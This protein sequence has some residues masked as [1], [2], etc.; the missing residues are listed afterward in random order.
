MSTAVEPRH[1]EHDL[2]GAGPPVVLIHS[3]VADARLW[4]AQVEALAPTHR[5]VTYDRP[6]FGRSPL[7]PGPFSQVADL[8]GLL[9]G[10]GLERVSLVGCSGGG[11]VALDFVLT[12]PERVDRLVLVAPGLAGWDWSAEMEAAD[13]EETR[14]FEAGDDAGAAEAQVRT[15]ADGQR[16][17]E[18]VDPALREYT[19][20]AV[21]RSYAHYRA[22]LESG[23]PGPA[24]RPDPPASERLGDVRAPTLV[25]IGE[26]D[27][28]DL[29]G[30]ADRLVAGIP[31][32]RKEVVADAAH[33]LPM[34][35]P[36]ELNRRLLEFL[37]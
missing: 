15:W 5:V 28:E 12:H 27:V 11:N 30:V 21:L 10:L 8:R 6:G 37:A 14:L 33:M 24:E 23:E 32:A 3:D 7:P 1:V 13:E 18:E 26:A 19:R 35:R 9:D 29:H 36:D 22:A 34:E 31:D 2:T 20:E 4:D 16:H 17:P 25:V